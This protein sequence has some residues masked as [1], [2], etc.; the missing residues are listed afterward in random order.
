MAEKAK[1]NTASDLNKLLP[2]A[3][4]EKYKIVNTGKRSSTTVYYPKFGVIDFKTLSVAKAK[5]LVKLKAPFI[6]EKTSTTSN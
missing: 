4:A 5:H 1:H 3:T 2:K 6:E